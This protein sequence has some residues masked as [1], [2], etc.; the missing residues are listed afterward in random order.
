MTT[1][2]RAFPLVRPPA[3]VE[4]FIAELR[5]PRRE[6]TSQF[7]RAYG[8]SHESVHLQDTPHGTLLIVATWIDDVHDAAPRY[9]AASQGFH[10]WFKDRVQFLTGVNLDAMPLGP[11][12][13]EVFAW[14]AAAA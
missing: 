14:P 9:Q 1:L 4:A 11:P 5:G 8:V 2:V 13:R 10:A 7:Y 6:E 3:D 12:A